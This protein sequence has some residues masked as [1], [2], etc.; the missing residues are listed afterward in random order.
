LS[1]EPAAVAGKAD[2]TLPYYKLQETS[3]KIQ[4]NF[5]FQITN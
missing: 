3:Y 1:A 2:A 5:K 4:T